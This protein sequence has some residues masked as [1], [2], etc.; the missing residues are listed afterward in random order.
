MNGRRLVL[1]L[2]QLLLVLFGLGVVLVGP[3]ASPASAICEGDITPV[4]PGSGPLG[5]SVDPPAAPPKGDP[6]GDKKAPWLET[7]GPSTKWNTYDLGCGPDMANHPTSKPFTAEANLF[8]DQALLPVV[9]SEELTNWVTGDPFGFLD[10]V[11]KSVQKKVEDNVFAQLM[12]LAILGLGAYF[13]WKSR[14]ALAHETATTAIGAVLIVGGAVFL[15]QWPQRANDAFQDVLQAGVDVAQSPFGQPDFSDAMFNDVVYPHWLAGEV[16]SPDSDVARKYGPD[17]YRSQH[18]TYAEV[19]EAR[20]AQAEADANDQGPGQLSDNADNGD[21]QCG[22]NQACDNQN[23]QDGGLPPLDPGDSGCGV[24]QAECNQTA[25]D[26]LID[27]KRELFKD[28]ASKVESEDPAAYDVLTGRDGADN[29]PGLAIEATVYLWCTSAFY[30]ISQFMLGLAMLLVRAAIVAFPILAPLVIFPKFR[31]KLASLLDLVAAA[32]L[33]GFKFMFASGLYSTIA[34]GIL[35]SPQAMLLKVI[36]LVVLAVVGLLL[37]R[38]IRTLKTFMP[39]ADPNHSYLAAALKR[40]LDFAVTSSAVETGIT[41]ANETKPAQQPEL[42][43]AP[44]RRMAEEETMP[45]LEPMYRPSRGVPPTRPA[46]VFA[47]RIDRDGYSPAPRPIAPLRT[48]PAVDP[49]LAGAPSRVRAISASGVPDYSGLAVASTAP[50]HRAEPAAPPGMVT[51]AFDED[52]PIFRAS[53]GL[54]V[55]RPSQPAPA[56]LVV[57]GDGREVFVLFRTSDERHAADEG[58]VGAGA[59]GGAR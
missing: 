30:I 22:V 40:T 25:M 6:L 56:D 4:Q 15:L 48:A 39:G 28:T 51:V 3:A 13:V 37:L 55:N 52:A 14:S 8:L 33:G 17:L 24:N 41:A 19:A 47:E 9:I 21:S 29:R 35:A 12:P 36:L 11:V 18:L 38:P 16:G 45:G 50:R 26:D 44:S 57:D 10:P 31:P 23:E 49:E 27:Q 5:L 59:S 32:L 53:E 7:Y 20:A 2:G 46:T 58:L 42:A 34:Q 43:P 54:E 1:R